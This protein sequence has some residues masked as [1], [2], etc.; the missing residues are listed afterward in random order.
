MGPHICKVNLPHVWLRSKCAEKNLPKG[1]SEMDPQLETSSQCH[2][3]IPHHQLGPLAKMI[4][5]K[6]KKQ[7][8]KQTT[9]KHS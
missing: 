9:K 1:P 5:E 8:H 4:S 7:T 6:K 3:R 2:Q